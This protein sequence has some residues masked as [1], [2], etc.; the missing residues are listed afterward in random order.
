M[1][2]NFKSI[3]WLPVI[4]T[5]LTVSSCKDENPSPPPVTDITP[6]GDGLKVIGYALLGGAVVVAL[7]R[8]AR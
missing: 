5:L 7:G 3:L 1:I 8:M 2:H 6:V 4:G